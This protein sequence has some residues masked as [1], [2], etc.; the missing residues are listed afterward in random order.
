MKKFA[1]VKCS[2]SINFSV[3]SKGIPFQ[4][5]RCGNLQYTAVFPAV[6]QEAEKG[7]SPEKLLIDE[8]ATCFFHS[9]KVASVLCDECGIF[10][11][12][13]CDLFID[14]KHFCPRC[15]KSNKGKIASLQNRTILYDSIMLLLAL[16]PL[17]IIYLTII[18]APVTIIGSIYF[19]NKVHTPY[20]RGKWRFIL[21]IIISLV[22]LF[23]WGAL[24]ITIISN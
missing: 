5:G 8:H 15:L 18:T 4:C 9:D 20:K 11:C 12:D 14:G 23:G 22:E 16:L 10:L 1:C 2:N 6:F 7:N 3:I 19:W 17:L 24:F 21:A 13:L